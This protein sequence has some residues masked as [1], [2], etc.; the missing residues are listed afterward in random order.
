MSQPK[1]IFDTSRSLKIRFADFCHYEKH[2]QIQFKHRSDKV[3]TVPQSNLKK[4]RKEKINK[5]A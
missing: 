5:T 4:K 1:A 3:T 2:F